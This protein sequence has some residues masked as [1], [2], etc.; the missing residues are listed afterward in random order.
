MSPL[1]A[2]VNFHTGGER[3]TE[4]WAADALPTHEVRHSRR[5]VTGRAAA[6]RAAFGAIGVAWFA[7][8]RI[9]VR[10][11][12]AAGVAGLLPEVRREEAAGLTIRVAWASAGGARTVASL[13]LAELV[14]FKE[15]RRT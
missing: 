8:A 13:A 10:P 14:A 12:G 9:V 5:W 1:S 3:L 7:G 4:A 15:A 2:F 6:R 11:A